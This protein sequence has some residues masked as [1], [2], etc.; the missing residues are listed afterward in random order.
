MKTLR[1]KCMKHKTGK[2][3]FFSLYNGTGKEKEKKQK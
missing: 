2:Q 3:K 1:R